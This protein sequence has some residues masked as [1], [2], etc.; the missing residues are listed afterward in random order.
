MDLKSIE[1]GVD[2]F[3]LT[4]FELLQNTN[5][6]QGLLD[7]VVFRNGI[8]LVVLGVDI[9]DFESNEAIM[10]DIHSFSMIRTQSEM[11]L[12]VIDG[13][14]FENS[15]IGTLPN[16]FEESEFGNR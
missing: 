9:D 7:A 8:D 4:I 11:V 12:E 1:K 15:A 6:V 13:L 10:L 14:R 2:V 5:L 16:E 3:G